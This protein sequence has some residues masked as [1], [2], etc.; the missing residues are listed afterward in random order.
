MHFLIGVIVVAVLWANPV[1]RS[2]LVGAIVRTTGRDCL[3]A[4][5]EEEG[6]ELGVQPNS[7]W[8]PGRF[9]GVGSRV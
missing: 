5:P 9:H 3:D 7:L 8:P 1:T 6:E 2:L 4:T